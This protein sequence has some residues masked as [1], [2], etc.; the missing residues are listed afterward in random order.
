MGLA[1]TIVVLSVEQKEKF[2]SVTN[3]YTLNPSPLLGPDGG[4]EHA[5]VLMVRRSA[6]QVISNKLSSNVQ[7]YNT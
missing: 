4:T 3:L 2:D 5:T 7:V 6:D 1:P